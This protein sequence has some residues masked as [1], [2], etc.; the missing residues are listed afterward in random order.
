MDTGSNFPIYLT[1]TAAQKYKLKN[2]TYNSDF[3]SNKTGT[4]GNANGYTFLS[5]SIL[6]GNC[7]FNKVPI[8]ASTD[9][10]GSMATNDFEGI[11]GNQFLE[12]FTFIINPIKKELL[13]KPYKKNA[14]F[15]YNLLGFTLIDR[16]DIAP[17]YWGIKAL[18]SKSIAENSGLTLNDKITKINN[19]NV[20]KINLKQFLKD[21]RVGEN[22]DITVLKNNKEHVYPLILKSVYK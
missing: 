18:L 19:K 13:L 12:N 3:I 10:A 16:T 21:L 2:I 11:L 8:Y 4:G 9:S 14:E 17:Y 22:I 1:S 15:D 7:E 5:K 6:I 20:V